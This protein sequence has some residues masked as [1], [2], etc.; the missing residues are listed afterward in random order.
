MQGKSALGGQGAEKLGLSGA[1]V[2]EDAL[3]K[4][5]LRGLRP[6]GREVLSARAVKEKGKGER[7]ATLNCTFSTPKSV[8][9]V[10]L[11]VGIL[12]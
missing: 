10:A 1:V 6:D 8:N 3:K 12:V 7:R 2:V 9:L 4:V 11:L 5:S